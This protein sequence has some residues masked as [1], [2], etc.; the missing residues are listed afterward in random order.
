M[1]LRIDFPGKS[2]AFVDIHICLLAFVFRLSGI[3]MRSWDYR[4]LLHRLRVRLSVL[5]GIV[6]K[7]EERTKSNVY[8]QA[9]SILPQKIPLMN[10]LFEKNES[11]SRSFNWC[12][13]WI[14]I[15]ACVM[16]S[17]YFTRTSLHLVRLKIFERIKCLRGHLHQIQGNWAGRNFVS[18][19][20]VNSRL[21]THARMHTEMKMFG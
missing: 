2:S 18:E 16:S 20:R 15:P 4:C 13:I 3:G 11:V 12:Q 5:V 14:G 21:I 6:N 17:Q 7:R 9:R 19:S 8:S 1:N 10:W